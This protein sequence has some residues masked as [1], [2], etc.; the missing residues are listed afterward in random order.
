MARNAE[1]TFAWA[2]GTYTFRLAY[3]ELAELQEKSGVGPQL[4]L[5]RL[6]D[7]SWRVADA[8]DTIRLGLIGG[9]KSPV[10]AMKLCERYVRER[11][12]IESLT[13][14]KAI[15]LA[16]LSGVE[17]EE[18]PGKDGSGATQAGDLSPMEGSISPDFMDKPQ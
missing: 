1:I 2:D 16:A 14:A 9:G 13:P 6:I 17:G 18:W 3:G 10:D 12:L 5:S 15:L 8:Y 4:L 11:P 7:G